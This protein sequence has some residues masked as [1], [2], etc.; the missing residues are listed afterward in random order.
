LKLKKR[1]WEP[2]RNHIHHLLID[3]CF[4]HKKASLTINL[5]LLLFNSSVILALSTFGTIFGLIIIIVFIISSI[6]YLNYI[7]NNFPKSDM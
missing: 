2:D 4:T 1:I 7:D 3:I 6:I 5:I